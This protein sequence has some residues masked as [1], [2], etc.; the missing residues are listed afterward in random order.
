MPIF[1]TQTLLCKAMAGRDTRDE[2]ELDNWFD[3]PDT[4]G[5]VGGALGKVGAF[6]AEAVADAQR[7]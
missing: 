2:Q 4:S 6:T 3:E 5:R 1:G 7:R